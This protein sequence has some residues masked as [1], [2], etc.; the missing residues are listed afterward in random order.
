MFNPIREAMIKH[1]ENIQRVNQETTIEL[2]TSWF[3]LANRA[4][5]LG[6]WA[7][8]SVKIYWQSVKSSCK[9]LARNLRSTKLYSWNLQMWR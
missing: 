5:Y 1:R 7:L 6:A 4:K 2:I 8:S 9:P 3:A